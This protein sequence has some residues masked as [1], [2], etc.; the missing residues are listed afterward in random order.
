MIQRV[1]LIVHTD[2]PDALR[3]TREAIEWLQERGLQVHVEP[4]IAQALNMPEY[5]CDEAVLC[6]SHLLI[7]LGGDGTILRASHLAAPRAIPILG[8]HLGRFGF[9]A[10][11]KPHD[12][13]TA[14]A[15]VQAGDYNI[16]KRL[17]VRAVAYREG[18][19]I[20]D[21]LALNDVVVTKGA[22]ARMI[23]LQTFVN[24]TFLATYSADG[25]VVATPTGSTAYSLS[26][27]G[28]IVDPACEVLLLT[29]ICAH[30]L[31]ARPLVLPADKQVKVVVTA[32]D[33]DFHLQ[34]DGGETVRLRSGDSVHVFRA[35]ERTHLIVFDSDE[36]YTK[37]RDR[38]LWGERVNV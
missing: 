9:I 3:F 21:A 15:R 22:V 25:V 8:V 27:G 1:G 33:G 12:L 28:A 34:A 10:Q 32:D 31:S 13:H 4:H 38:L 26:A 35:E 29:P 30:T 2:K 14:I 7:A 37:L 18:E 6:E 23:T 36:F 19:P 16:E 24:D 17:M 5:G 20:C 11:V